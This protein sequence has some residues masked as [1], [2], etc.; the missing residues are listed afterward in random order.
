[1]K[2]FA[3]HYLFVPQK[4]FLKQYVV[5]LEGEY[6]AQYF[7]LT[8]EIE[9]VEWLPGIIELTV[10]ENKFHA[11]HQYPFDFIAMHPVG[12]TRRKQLL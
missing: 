4:G 1:M 3:S 2:R 10:N 6:V 5:E 12:E 11:Y 8:E 7:P 9:S